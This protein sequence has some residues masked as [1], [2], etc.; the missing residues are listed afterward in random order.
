MSK[1]NLS[2]LKIAMRD[3][4]LIRY[5]R[6][7]EEWPDQGYV[8]EIGPRFFL[9]A[10]VSNDIR[11]NGFQ[12]VRIGDLRNPRPAPYATF[13][14]AALRK[15]GERG[16]KR[17]RV[18]VQSI[19]GI[20]VSA[21]KIFPIVTIHRERIEPDTCNIGRVLGV[22]RGR[23]SLLEINPD[24]TWDQAPTEYRIGEITRV[25]FGG[26]YEEALHLVGGEPPKI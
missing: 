16:P 17:P 8:L 14:E 19:E 22:N 24:A 5:S 25:D 15:R 26:D 20:L 1:R 4:R 21:N 13:I 2:R 11:F 23:L 10:L 12:C 9:F 6:R 7:F 18:S 3:H